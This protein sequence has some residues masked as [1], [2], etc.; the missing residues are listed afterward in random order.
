MIPKQL[1]ERYQILPGSKVMITES[2]KGILIVPLPPNPAAA[3]RGM[4]KGHDLVQELIKA[5]AV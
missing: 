4:L 5:R 1:R 3:F 2:E